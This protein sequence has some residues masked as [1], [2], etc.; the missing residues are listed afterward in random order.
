MKDEVN[1]MRFWQH[2]KNDPVV[3]CTI[4]DVRE[5]QEREGTNDDVLTA[6][7]IQSINVGMLPNGKTMRTEDERLWEQHNMDYL[8]WL[9]KTYHM[10]IMKHY[11][12]LDDSKASAHPL[13]PHQK[14]E[15]IICTPTSEKA[16]QNQIYDLMKKKVQSNAS[17]NAIVPPPPVMATSIKGAQQ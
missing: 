3:I 10:L 7:E 8:A 6:E 17:I 2:D 9:E 5:S 4:Q 12:N 16:K 15:V 13:T 1:T 14:I 11:L